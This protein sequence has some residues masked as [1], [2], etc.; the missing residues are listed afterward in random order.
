MNPEVVWPAVDPL[1]S[2][3][4]HLAVVLILGSAIVAWLATA[5]CLCW[6]C[7][8]ERLRISG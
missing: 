1:V 5:C 6:L 3:V 7:W 8:R 4:A 2:D